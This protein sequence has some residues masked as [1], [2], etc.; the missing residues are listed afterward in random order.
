MSIIA[1]VT[2]SA[3]RRRAGLFFP[4]GQEQIVELTGE[5]D[6][7]LKPL[8][9]DPVLVVIVETVTITPDAPKPVGD[10]LNTA[11]MDALAKLDPDGDGKNLKVGE[12]I[13][14]L[15][16]KVTS[17]EIKAARDT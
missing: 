5:D 11:I 12:I 2:A 14:A 17:K 16:F 10:E 6:P 4:K 1:K 3:N 7:V 8:K 15:G 13:A 9:D